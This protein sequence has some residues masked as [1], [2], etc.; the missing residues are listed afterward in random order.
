MRQLPIICLATTALTSP[1]WAGS[2]MINPDLDN[3]L[4]QTANG[5]LSN[6]L[7]DIYVGRT[8]QADA[9]SRRR[10]AIH[11]DVHG[12]VPAGSTINSVTLRLWLVS[13][14]DATTRT[15]YVH[16]A[17]ASWGEGSS[18]YNGGL[19]DASTTNDAT[20]VHRFH[21]GTSWSSAGGDYNGTASASASCGSSSATA[22]W[23]TWSSATM[24]GEVQDWLDTP[25]SNHGWILVGDE[26]TGGT[27]RR[28][29]SR[30][31]VDDASD[32]YPELIIDYTPPPG[33]AAPA[34]ASRRAPAAAVGGLRVLG[35]RDLDGDGDLE[36]LL[37]GRGGA[38][39]GGRSTPSGFRTWELVLERTSQDPLAVHAE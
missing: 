20:W 23:Y 12:N 29:T 6:A 5:T 34:A 26:S 22:Q 14:G 21:S 31:G 11:F 3:T 9:S 32:H 27:A 15:C 18:Y 8:G 4:I 1:V 7:G 16:E 33:L 13:A 38:L 28:F 30:E 19:G 36:L 37:R 10:G 35:A 17:S 2:I 39:L 25:S 24:A